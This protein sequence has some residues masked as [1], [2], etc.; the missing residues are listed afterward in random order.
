MSGRMTTSELKTITADFMVDLL[1][2]HQEKETISN[3]D[4]ENILLKI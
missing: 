1:R 2:K 4:I 3:G